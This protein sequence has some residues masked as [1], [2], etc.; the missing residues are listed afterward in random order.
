MK[1]IAYGDMVQQTIPENLYYMWNV[2]HGKVNA[3]FP[4][5]S[6]FGINLSGVAAEQVY[7]SRTMVL[8][9]SVF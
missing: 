6:G 3:F 5:N 1:I 4:W 8:A 2:L 7:L 9:I